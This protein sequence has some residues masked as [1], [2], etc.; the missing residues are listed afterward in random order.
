M[1]AASYGLLLHGSG[2]AR[3]RSGLHYIAVNLL[4]SALF[5]VGVAML[6]GVTGTLAM[7]D[8]AQKLAAIPA[9]DRGLLHAGVAILAVA[10][11]AKA[12]MW[13]LGF[14]LVPAYSAASAPARRRCSRSRPRSASTRWSACG[15]SSSRPTG[16]RPR[17][18][19]TRWW[20]A[21]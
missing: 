3:V 17:S 9:A 21:A 7:A 20:R 16:R 4:A 6:Y 14:W 11:L 10:F 12:A 13:P 15:R 2:T 5:L 1:L 18:A 19:P 8:M